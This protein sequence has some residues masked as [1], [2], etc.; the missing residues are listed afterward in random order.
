MQR[1][2][3]SSVSIC[4]SPA[5]SFLFTVAISSFCAIK[6][7]AMSISR[8]C[9]HFPPGTQTEISWSNQWE[10]PTGRQTNWS[11]NE[12]TIDCHGGY[13]HLL[14]TV[15][16]QTNMRKII[17]IDFFNTWTQTDV[18]RRRMNVNLR[19]KLY[20]PN[21]MTEDLDRRLWSLSQCRSTA[22]CSISGEKCVIVKFTLNT[23]NR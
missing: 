16:V 11:Y 12:F 18:W 2:E 6:V 7:K 1:A 20:C 10:G 4:F 8:L 13:V 23:L 15:M 19:E 5:C 9:R 21:W 22:S 3:V 17:E 14:Y